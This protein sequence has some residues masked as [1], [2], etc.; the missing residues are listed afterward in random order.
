MHLLRFQSG[1]SSRCCHAGH[2]GGY[3]CANIMGNLGWQ[4][5][6]CAEVIQVV[7]VAGNLHEV[8]VIVVFLVL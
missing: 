7:E 2:T 5:S 6:T 8:I 1:K 3:Q 4:E